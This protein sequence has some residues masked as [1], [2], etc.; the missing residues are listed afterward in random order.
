M[1]NA[2][3]R[4]VLEIPDR[5]VPTRHLNQLRWKTKHK[6]LNNEWDDILG[7]NAIKR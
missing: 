2:F 3:E 1:I 5:P 7:I 6:E 4:Y